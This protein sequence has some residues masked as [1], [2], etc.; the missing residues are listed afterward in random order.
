MMTS[1]ALRMFVLAA[2]LWA[3][4]PGFFAWRWPAIWRLPVRPGGTIGQTTLRPG[5][6]ADS[7]HDNVGAEHQV[8]P[9][10]NS[11][12]WLLLIGVMA[13]LI[14]GWILLVVLT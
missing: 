10:G 3:V 9:Q 7:P 11:V 8:A 12:G 5:G 6:T 14:G 13:L 4:T 2:A 1:F